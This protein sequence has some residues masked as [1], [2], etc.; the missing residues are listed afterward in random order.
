MGA[1]P[2][3]G[4]LERTWTCFRPPICPTSFLSVG[5]SPRRSGQKRRRL[6]CRSRKSQIVTASAFLVAWSRDPESAFLVAWSHDP[7]SAFLAAW[8]RDPESAF[9][10]TRGQE[11]AV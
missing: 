1:E 4:G 6:S 8:S 2:P 7:E 10:R 11:I 9:S 5:L 3:A